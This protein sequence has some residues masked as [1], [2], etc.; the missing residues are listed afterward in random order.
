MGKGGA[1]DPFGLHVSQDQSQIFLFHF[2][3]IK[4]TAKDRKHFWRASHQ[5]K[6]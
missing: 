6:A 1:N 2:S 4:K 5:E 3:S